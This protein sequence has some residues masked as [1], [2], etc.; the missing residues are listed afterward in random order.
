MPWWPAVIL[1]NTGCIP[2]MTTVFISAD[3]YAQSEES[4][5][6]QFAGFAVLL[7]REK[8][9]APDRW[10]P[11]LRASFPSLSAY[12]SVLRGSACRAALAC[13]FVEDQSALDVNGVLAREGLPASDGDVDE[14]R[15]ELE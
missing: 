9:I 2:H 12:Q 3:S 5:H 4:A 13:D 1:V 14:T 15:L 11:R 10:R 8:L 7:E 6:H